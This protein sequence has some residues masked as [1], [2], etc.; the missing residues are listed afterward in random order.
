MFM[1]MFVYVYVCTMLTLTYSVQDNNAY[2]HKMMDWK[3]KYDESDNAVLRASKLLTEEDSDIMGGLF[4]RTELSEVSRTVR[5][6]AATR[7]RGS[8]AFWPRSDPPLFVI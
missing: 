4:Q 5:G 8:G 3:T 2:V 1:F 6:A 7:A